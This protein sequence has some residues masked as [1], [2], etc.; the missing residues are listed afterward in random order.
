MDE[1]FPSQT[2]KLYEIDEATELQQNSSSVRTPV[3]EKENS[4]EIGLIVAVVV[5]VMFLVALSAVGI[6]FV[7]LCVCVK[8][9]KSLQRNSG[10]GML[11]DF[12]KF[13]KIMLINV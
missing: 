2:T 7:V 5:S 13:W 11:I 4:V 1:L 6:C 8:Q 10:I 9:R 12:F 3:Q